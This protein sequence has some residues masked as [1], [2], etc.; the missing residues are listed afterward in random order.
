MLE[1]P[2]P[3]PLFPFSPFPPGRKPPRILVV[4][5][6]AS[7][8]DHAAR[9][10]AAIRES[11]PQ[12]EFCG[13]GGEAMSAAGVRILTPAADIAV[14]GLLEVAGHLTAIWQA[15]RTIGKVLKTA[16]PDLAILVDFPDFNFWVARLARYYRVP[17]MYYISP[18][19][20]AWRTYRVRTLARLTERM[21]VIFPFEADF[22]RQRGVA[23][24]Y[25]GHPFRETLPPLTDRRT[26]LLEHN[27]DP[28]AL[29]IAL[30]PGSRAGE[31]ERHLPI[32]LKAA[33]L[34]RRSIPQT[35]FILPLA[36]TAPA[37]LVQSMVS[38][39]DIVGAGFKPDPTALRLSIIPGQAYQALG[40]AHA[41]AV[42]SGTAT[43][44]AALAGA[45]TVIVYRVSPLTFAVARRLVRVEHVGM[46]NLLAG[47][48][49]F[50]ELI[51]D[52][53]TPERLAHEVLTLIQDPGRIKAVRRGLATVIRRLGGPGASAR[54]ARV[55]VE[56]MGSK[57]EPGR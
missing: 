36:S 33:E 43:V 22:Y 57:N 48:R 24:D 11:C 55:A 44:E 15:L 34:I 31:I 38:G 46:A 45:P 14:V 53:F 39:E 51:Q 26:F 29:T 9:L 10:V 49:V 27:L 30:L 18:Q 40:A 23:V 8:D 17:V 4:A 41:A 3:F 1:Q 12:A 2:P 52:D 54:A 21:A 32:M 28:E 35:Q 16:R 25:V 47:E 19:V 6:E 20:W 42:A 13:V 5:G 7:G 37:E 50:P 56:L